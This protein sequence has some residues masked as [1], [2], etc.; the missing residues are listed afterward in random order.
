M[1]RSVLYHNNHHY[2]EWYD[3]NEFLV[4]DEIDPIPRELWNWGI[5]NRTGRL[6]KQPE[7]IV[8]L[9]LL[10][11]GTATVT[12]SGILFKG[13]YY[14][15]DLAT[16]EQWYTRA[17]VRGSWKVKVCYDPRTTNEIYLWLEDG[18]KFE[19]CVL[20]EREERYLNKRFEE[21][22]DLLEI[23]KHS[24]REKLDSVMRAKIEL[25]AYTKAVVEEAVRKTGAAIQKSALSDRN[26]IEKNR[27]RRKMEKEMNRTQ[28]AF[29]L[30]KPPVANERKAQIVPLSAN[31]SSHLETSYIPPAKKISQIKAYL[32]E[33]DGEST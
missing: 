30:G 4:A 3:R 15:C 8:K 24:T 17:R 14:G 32:K 21:V 27:Q 29:V 5:K 11:Q 20:L 9:N 16:K 10:Y 31:D 22:E 28:E 19:T 25:D 7:D 13:M 6:K 18:K 1:I 26:R 2:M 23:E 12:P 33:D